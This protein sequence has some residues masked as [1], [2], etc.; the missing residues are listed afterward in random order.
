MSPKKTMSPPLYKTSTEHDAPL[1]LHQRRPIEDELDFESPAEIPSRAAPPPNPELS[2]AGIP[3]E[4]SVTRKGP[5][6]FGTYIPK[7]NASPH[8]LTKR[9][10]TAYGLGSASS[11]FIDAEHVSNHTR[12]LLSLALRPGDT[13]YYEREDDEQQITFLVLRPRGKNPVFP[14]HYQRRRQIGDGYFV[15]QHIQGF[16]DGVVLHLP[17]QIVGCCGEHDRRP[18]V[19]SEHRPDGLAVRE[20]G[21]ASKLT[22][23]EKTCGVLADVLRKARPKA[24]RFQ[25]FVDRIDEGDEEAIKDVE[26]RYDARIEKLEKQKV[27]YEYQAYVRE[28]SA[29][30]PTPD[31]EDLFPAPKRP[32]Q[33]V[34]DLNKP[35]P[36]LPVDQDSRHD[37]VLS[38]VMT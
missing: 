32:E 38:H 1:K 8:V 5:D 23:K 12:G 21:H 13:V 24:L 26:G 18:S 3:D 37:S 31:L 17:I 15:K 6:R 4:P 28:H 19:E 20:Y 9:F 11:A 36:A 22:V 16:E 34:V 29:G 25:K 7:A 35:L 14:E 2:T 27:W 30:D 10:E 33:R